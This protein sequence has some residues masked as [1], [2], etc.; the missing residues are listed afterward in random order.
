MRK[1]KI[2]MIS[3]SDAICSPVAGVGPLTKRE[4]IDS[5]VVEG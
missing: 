4:E 1:L 2:G 5:G 3:S